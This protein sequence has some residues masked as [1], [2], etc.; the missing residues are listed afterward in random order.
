MFFRRP[1][2]PHI[3]FAERL[4]TLRKLGFTVEPHGDA[5]E[6]G[7][8]GCAAMIRESGIGHAG[9]LVGGEI[10]Y[11]VDGGFQKLWKTDSGKRGPALA[12][13]L[14]ALHQFE[15]DLREALGVE[16]WFNQSL[17]TTC[18]LHVYDRLQGRETS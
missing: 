16:S 5:Y 7:R 18:D 10:G 8:N 6:A 12:S 13:Q 4:E 11:L 1:K 2:P 17:G 3:T 9:W 14:T 15:E